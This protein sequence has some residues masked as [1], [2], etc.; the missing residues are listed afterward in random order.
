MS[1]DLV[2]GTPNLACH[3]RCKSGSF[4]FGEEMSCCPSGL[5]S[6]V[7]PWESTGSD[8]VD[9]DCVAS[10]PWEHPFMKG[11]PENEAHLGALVSSV[12]SKV[13]GKIATSVMS[14]FEVPVRCTTEYPD[15]V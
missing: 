10:V 11:S 12:D 1:I 15:P 9:V 3:V 13:V 6:T 7:L 2:L 8:V 4:T 5:L 14:K